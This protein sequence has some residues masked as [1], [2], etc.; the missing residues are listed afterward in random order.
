MTLFDS[1]RTIAYGAKDQDKRCALAADYMR[2]G[3]T[4]DWVL[5]NVCNGN[6]SIARTLTSL[7][8]A[9]LISND[10]KSAELK[11]RRIDANGRALK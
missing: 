7:V 4:L 8:G 6:Q 3:K 1:A 5:A 2:S 11:D 9:R 10:Q